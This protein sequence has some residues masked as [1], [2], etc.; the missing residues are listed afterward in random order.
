MTNDEAVGVLGLVVETAKGRCFVTDEAISDAYNMA[1]NALTAQAEKTQLSEEDATFNCISIQA[2]NYAIC[3][4]CGMIDCDQTDKCEKLFTAQPETHEKRTETHSCDCIS[5]KAAIEWCLEGLNN[6]PSA[7][8]EQPEWAQKVEEYRQNAPQ[9]IHNPLAW[10]LYQ[11][12][13]EYDR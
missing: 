11:V 3:N 12:W 8:P 7:Q 6:M 9:H 10:A 2:A 1:I 4:A 13:K 5:R